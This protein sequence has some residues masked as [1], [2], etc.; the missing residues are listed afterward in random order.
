MVILI[1]GCKMIVD[2]RSFVLPHCPIVEM[3]SSTRQHVVAVAD[4]FR[5]ALPFLVVSLVHDRGCTRRPAHTTSGS[6][7]T[8]FHG[9]PVEIHM[10]W[11]RSRGF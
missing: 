8:W 1:A 7:G 11:L 5:L 6:N 9:I 10:I 2:I 3:V 4:D